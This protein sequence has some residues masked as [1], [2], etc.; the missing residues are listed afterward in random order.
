MLAP[1]KFYNYSDLSSF[2]TTCPLSSG[3][4]AQPKVAEVE[5]SALKPFGLEKPL[6][7]TEAQMFRL[8]AASLNMTEWVA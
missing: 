8:R 2:V 6:K 3:G 4:D 7:K 5:G 1:L